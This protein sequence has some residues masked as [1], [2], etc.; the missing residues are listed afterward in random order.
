MKAQLALGAVFCE[1]AQRISSGTDYRELPLQQ[2]TGDFASQ[3]RGFRPKMIEKGISLYAG[4]GRE[5]WEKV[6]MVPTG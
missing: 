2:S 5:S 4:Y 3:P 6:V 1:A